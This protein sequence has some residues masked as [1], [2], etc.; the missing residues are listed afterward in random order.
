[1]IA[2]LSRQ[3]NRRSMHVSTF[4]RVW[5]ATCHTVMHLSTQHT[6]PILCMTLL[7]SKYQQ[8]FLTSEESKRQVCGY[9]SCC[10]LTYTSST[11][12]SVQ[13]ALMLPD[14][15]EPVNAQSNSRKW[16]SCEVCVIVQFFCRSVNRDLW[17]FGWQFAQLLILP[18]ET[19]TS[20]TNFVFM[21][22]VFELG[23]RM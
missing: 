23:A 3:S 8:T 16:T 6:M 12:L 4:K 13:W 9:P 19:F 15:C 22:F 11:A 17:S 5:N 14:T 7:D 21:S 2:I 18:K 20:N 10:R 1:M